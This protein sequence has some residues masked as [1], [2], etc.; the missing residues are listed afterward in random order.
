TPERHTTGER[1]S[2]ETGRAPPGP[3]SGRPPARNYPYDV[4]SCSWLYVG[5]NRS[6]RASELYKLTVP[7]SS[8]GPTDWPAGARNPRNARGGEQ[9]GGWAGRA[10]RAQPAGPLGG[11]AHASYNTRARSPARERLKRKPV[12]KGGTMT[13]AAAGT[14]KR[15]F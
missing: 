4:S 1:H 10:A 14:E 11:G 6:G 7:E 5:R 8:K 12:G 13:A 3:C 2:T 9:R 15:E